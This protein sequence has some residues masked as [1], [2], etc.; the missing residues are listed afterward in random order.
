MIQFALSV[1]YFVIT[2]TLSVHGTYSQQSDFQENVHNYVIGQNFDW[3]ASCCPLNEITQM[4]HNDKAL[5]AL[6]LFKVLVIPEWHSDT[7]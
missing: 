7:S 2:F 3:V 5:L 1:L 4:L 6:S